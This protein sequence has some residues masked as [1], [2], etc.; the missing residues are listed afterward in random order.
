MSVV[1]FLFFTPRIS[2]LFQEH[3]IHIHIYWCKKA[4]Q[5]GYITDLFTQYFCHFCRSFK[6]TACFVSLGLS[7]VW[8][9]VYMFKSFGEASVMEIDSKLPFPTYKM[10]KSTHYA[11]NYHASAPLGTR[12]WKF[13]PLWETMLDRP[14][15]RKVSL[16]IRILCIC[17]CEANFS[18]S[19]NFT[20]EGAI[21]ELVT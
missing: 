17:K 21:V 20:Q 4:A 18:F 2:L 6:M 10:Y 16:P 13:P 19:Y 12:M 15:H 11:R 8:L 1:F 5:F 3:W 7:N 14:D 9:F